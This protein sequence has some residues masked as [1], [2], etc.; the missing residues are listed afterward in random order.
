MAKKNDDIRPCVFSRDNHCTVK[1]LGSM[2]TPP[3]WCKAFCSKYSP[4]GGADEDYIVGQID[5]SEL[6]EETREI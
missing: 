3:R 5:I 1:D 2:E 6:L 4:V